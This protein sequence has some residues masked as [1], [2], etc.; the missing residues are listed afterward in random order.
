MIALVVGQVH[1][2]QLQVLIQILDQS[3]ALHHQMHRS[4]PAAVHPLGS[5]SHLILNVAG[6][7][8]RP[9]LILPVLGL[10]AALNSVLAV[11]EDFG[12]ASIHSK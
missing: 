8:H 12:V 10:Q 2:E 9:R 3:Q 7:E 1:F 11:T 4:N 6:L 5:L